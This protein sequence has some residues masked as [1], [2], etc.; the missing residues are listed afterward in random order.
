MNTYPTQLNA[1]PLNECHLCPVMPKRKVTFQGV[2][3]EED[4]IV[5]PKKVRGPDSCVLGRS[6]EE[7]RN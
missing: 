3:D 5:V 2:G 6:E 7:K 4:E 1:S